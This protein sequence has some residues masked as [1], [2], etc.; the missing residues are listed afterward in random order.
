MNFPTRIRREWTIRQNMVLAIEPA[1]LAARRGRGWK[2]F[3][4][5]EPQRKGVLISR[6]FSTG[7][8]E[9]TAAL[10]TRTVAKSTKDS[11]RELNFKAR[12]EHYREVNEAEN[13][14]HV[15]A[16]SSTFQPN[17]EELRWGSNMQNALQSS[18]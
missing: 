4:I 2:I 5:T 9:R 11:S 15:F 14:G 17:G 16:M 12:Q 7:L 8:T 6:R 3:L 13:R 18:A 10:R 1:L